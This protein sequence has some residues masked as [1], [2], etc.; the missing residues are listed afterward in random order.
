M[1]KLT[2]P[3]AIGLTSLS[4][5]QEAERQTRY[6]LRAVYSC[7]MYIQYVYYTLYVHAVWTWLLGFAE[8]C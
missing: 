6:A 7:Y 1:R 5:V 3:A 4:L 2:L 8:A